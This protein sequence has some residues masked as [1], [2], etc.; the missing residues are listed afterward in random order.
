MEVTDVSLKNKNKRNNSPLLPSNL[1]GLIVGKSNS[2]KSVLLFNLLLKNGW[3]DYNNL[4]VFGNSL[5][6]PEYELIKKGYENKLRKDELLHIFQNKDPL[7]AIENYNGTRNGKITA[8]FFDN[9]DLIPDP[10]TLDTNLKNLLIL[11]DCY[12]G[13]QSNCN[14]S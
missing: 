4:L 8:E 12:L 11:D 10:K 9:C 13:R 14:L 3:L 6:Q 5:H 7:K 1:R 2:G